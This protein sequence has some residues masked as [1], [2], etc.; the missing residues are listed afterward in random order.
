MKERPHHLGL[1]QLLTAIGD[2]LASN[3]FGFYNK[4]FTVQTTL[5]QQIEVIQEF[6]CGSRIFSVDCG[7]NGIPPP[8]TN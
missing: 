7:G 4:V 8:V 3:N 6:L 2:T 1:Q 5:T